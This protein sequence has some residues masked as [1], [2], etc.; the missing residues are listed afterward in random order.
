M[1][2]ILF[3]KFNNNLNFIKK[4]NLNFLDN[5]ISIKNKLIKKSFVFNK[6]YIV[7]KEIYFKLV[8]NTIIIS[9][10]FF[11]NVNDK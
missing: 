1:F 6:N 8:D 5:N 3:K 11:K 2:Y 4:T 9:N 7:F 10:N